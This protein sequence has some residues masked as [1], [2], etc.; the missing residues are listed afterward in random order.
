M[1]I[2]TTQPLTVP[3]KVDVVADMFGYYLLVEGRR[4]YIPKEQLDSVIVA[5]S[6]VKE[7]QSAGH[8]WLIDLGEAIRAERGEL[9]ETPAERG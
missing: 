7:R 4:F 5:L 1:S 3:W 2:Q 9:K 6:M 8:D